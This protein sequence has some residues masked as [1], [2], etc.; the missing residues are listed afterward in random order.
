MN[1]LCAWLLWLMLAMLPGS[2]LADLPGAAFALDRLPHPADSVPAKD[3]LDGRFDA[4]FSPVGVQS[5]SGGT[6]FWLRLR[7]HEDWKASDPPALLIQQSRHFFFTVYGEA[8]VP[9]SLGFMQQ[10][11]PED[12]VRGALVFPL[13]PGLSRDQAIYLRVDPGSSSAQVSPRIKVLPLPRARGQALFHLRLA[14]FCGGALSAL[15]VMGGLIGVFLHERSF[16]YYAG[17]VASYAFY[18]AYALGE[19]FSL[20]VLDLALPAGGLAWN[21]PDCLISVFSC[22]LTSSLI[23]KPYC[24]SLLDSVF[25]WT[26]VSLVLLL[27][28]LVLHPARLDFVVAAF[29]N[30]SL[31]VVSAI[32][33]FASAQAWW[34]GCRAAAFFLVAWI[35][36]QGLSI[37]RAAATLTDS[38][39]SPQLYYGQPIAALFSAV[40]LGLVVTDLMREQRRALETAQHHARTDSLTGVLNRHSILE[41]LG[42][43][44]AK[45]RSS[46][47]SVS[48]LFI[49]LDL[50]KQIN[51]RYGHLA[52]DE[53]LRRIVAPVQSELRQSDAV[54]RYGGEEFLVVLRGVEASGAHAIAKRIRMRVA[55]Q[56]VCVEDQTIRLTCSIGL[57]SARGL[58]LDPD[59]LLKQAD[60]GLY[61]AKE[62]GRNRVWVPPTGWS[63]VESAAR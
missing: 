13:R 19:G 40:A 54:G 59:T 41:R 5:W 60:E 6:P 31:I 22:L 21:I 52:G 51:D 50:F 37:W 23:G 45:A 42:V 33:I 56:E 20:P 3:V 18:I 29:A 63:A 7:L 53:C 16:F 32:I 9:R 2:A 58:D 25:D 36:A 61:A 30:L 12:A 4:E 14:M 39:L 10:Q 8:R 55:A 28:L 43:V 27:A 15:A 26:I 46:G 11:F 34:R 47:Q 38:S 48:L 62:A 49:D 35:V 24:S 17:V 44:C 57:A 1:K